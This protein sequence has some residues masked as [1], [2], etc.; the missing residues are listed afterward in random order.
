MLRIAAARNPEVIVHSWLT[1]GTWYLVADPREFLL[2]GCVTIV[3]SARVMVACHP[4]DEQ[5]MRDF[6]A[7]AQ[8]HTSD[9]EAAWDT[10]VAGHWP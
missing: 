7:V 2:G 3:G 1:P 5:R 10:F 8:E 9:D 6:L 4:D